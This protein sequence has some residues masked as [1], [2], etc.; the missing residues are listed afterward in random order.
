VLPLRR[1]WPGVLR[2]PL[3]ALR[4]HRP[5]LTPEGSG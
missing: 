1:Y 5:M 3:R 4:R 2:R